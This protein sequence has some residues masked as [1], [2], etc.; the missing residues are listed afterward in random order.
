MYL[1]LNVEVEFYVDPPDPATGI[2]H[3]SIIVESAKLGD[4]DITSELTEADIET[5]IKQFKAERN[6]AEYCQYHDL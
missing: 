5:L 2:K 6:E 3:E 1:E 4:T